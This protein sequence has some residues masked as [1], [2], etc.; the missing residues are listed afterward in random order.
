MVSVKAIKNNSSRSTSECA[1]ISLLYSFN[2]VL[3]YNMSLNNMLDTLYTLNYLLMRVIT[4]N[5]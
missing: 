3:Y 1:E 4:M 2:I 5:N